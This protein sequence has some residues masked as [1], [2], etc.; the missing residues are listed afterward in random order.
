MRVKQYPLLVVRLIRRKWKRIGKA[1]EET[2]QAS[3]SVLEPFW[4]LACQYYSPM[5]VEWGRPAFLPGSRA[6]DF[7]EVDSALFAGSIA[8]EY[9]AFEFRVDLCQTRGVYEGRPL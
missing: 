3:S 5:T 8:A 9:R 2:R 6:R 7:I 4:W 1:T